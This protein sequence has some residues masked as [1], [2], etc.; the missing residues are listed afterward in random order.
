MM[1]GEAFVRLHNRE[2]SRI[3]RHAADDEHN[4]PSVCRVCTDRA[5]RTDMAVGTLVRGGLRLPKKWGI[6]SEQLK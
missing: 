1:A 2:P 6:L 3:T 5:W 4:N